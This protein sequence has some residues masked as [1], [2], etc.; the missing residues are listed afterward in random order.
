MPLEHA[1]DPCEDHERI[2][3]ELYQQVER[4]QFLFLGMPDR[5]GKHFLE[6]NIAQPPQGPMLSRYFSFLPESVREFFKKKLELVFIPKREAPYSG[7][8]LIKQ[9][10]KRDLPGVSVKLIDHP[11][12]EE[13]FD[14]LE[15]E[16][17]PIIALAIGC[18]NQIPD[19]ER[20]VEEIQKRYK[21]WAEM[22]KFLLKGKNICPQWMYKIPGVEALFAFFRNWATAELNKRFGEK[23]ALKICENPYLLDHLAPIVVSGNYGASAA[24]KILGERTILNQW[25][26]NTRILWDDNDE[27]ERKKAQGEEPFYGEGVHDML[28]FLKNLGFNILFGPNDPIISKVVAEPNPVPKN[29]FLKWLME[30]IGTSVPPTTKVNLN[31][32]TGCKNKCVFCNTAEHFRGEKRFLFH[33]VDEMFE[34]VME[35]VEEN[36]NNPELIPETGVWILDEN[37]GQNQEGF[38]RM[39]ELVEKSGENIRWGTSTDIKGLIEYKKKHGDFRGLVRGG[40]NSIWL[41][42]ESKA[43]VFD[44]RGDATPGQ[45]EEL[46]KELQGLGILIIGSFIVGLPIHTEGPTEINEDGSYKKLNIYEDVKWW[47]G[48]GTA[49]N[50]VI[51]YT[52]TILVKGAK[53][54]TEKLFPTQRTSI[55]LL[56]V[57]DSQFGHVTVNNQTD[58]PD[59]RLEEL[60]RLAR[61]EFFQE[62]GPVAIRSI[63]A[64][65]DGFKVLKDSSD[66][67]EKRAAAY[68]YW[69][70]KRHLHLLSLATLYFSET[71]FE[72]CSDKFL[73]SFAEFLSEVENSAPPESELS[74][75]YSK[76]FNQYDSKISPI[77]KMVA[78][79]LRHRF[80][81]RYANQ[82]P[83]KVA[84][85]QTMQPALL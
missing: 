31:V 72:K 36:R 59:E 34:A 53:A 37:M 27:R 43:N 32:S 11:K 77:A 58:I 16:Y 78:D 76:V 4:P 28:L 74:S 55:D 85:E 60:D 82:E 79:T 65:W 62:N 51:M 46:I 25:H 26:N 42:I 19:A 41:G 8:H 15:Q 23:L 63:I 21:R 70:A 47:I 75:Q 5:T 52:E 18:E 22:I 38:E 30:V 61:E 64:L 9:N 35:K 12:G 10:L 39:C 48:L 20:L 56:G 83:Q 2:R 69:M 13:I 14:L 71:L 40:L 1:E 6:M 81:K 68:D 84:D 17:Y 67:A 50:Q 66:P 80:I 44:K 49:A 54:L 24:K 7:L 3:N 57:S 29:P 73:Q 33:S 45:V